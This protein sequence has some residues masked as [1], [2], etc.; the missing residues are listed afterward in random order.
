MRRYCKLVV[1]LLG[2]TFLFTACG[3]ENGTDT[4]E[5]EISTQ[6]K[7]EKDVQS[8]VEKNFDKNGITNFEEIDLSSYEEQAG[9]SLKDYVSY[10]FYYE[11]DGL[12]IEGYLSAPAEQIKEDNK[13]PCLIFNHG[14]NQDYGA[15]D[16]VQTTYY[17]YVFDTIC[18]ASNYRGCGDSEGTDSFG[19]DDVDDVIRLVDICK[20]FD[21]VDSDKIN[22]LGIS[23]GGMM[24]YEALRAEKEIHKAVVVSG[25]ADSFMEYEEREDMQSIYKELVG[26]T[27]DELPEE[28]EKRSATYWAD[29]IDTP[30]LIFHTTGDEKVSCA[31]ADKIV[32]KLK[33]NGK[34]CEYITFDSNEHAQ[35][36]NE[37]VEKI[38][39]WF[40]Q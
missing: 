8:L 1:M 30:L 36:R 22:M 5:V 37:D 10:H 21:Y 39:E 35:L 15:L 32:D 9:I 40:L 13:N 34:E 14:G 23:R 18:V 25:L 6:E 27:P 3:K 29:E 11:S 31:Q 4:Q 33:E 24:T 12:M 38:K 7:E 16:P 28:Y 17:S 20:N 26:G 2:M 19:G